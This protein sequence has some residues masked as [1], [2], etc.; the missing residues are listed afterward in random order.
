MQQS[1]RN[2]LVY[3]ILSGTIK[4][5]SFYY[6][7]PN[8]KILYDAQELYYET[9]EN[10]RFSGLIIKK[11][12]SNILVGKQ[13]LS[14]TIDSNIEEI[15]KSIENF[16]VELYQARLNQVKQSQTRKYLV[17]VKEKLE[18]SLSKK[19][20]LDLYTLEGY[21]E[22]VKNNFIYENCLVD[23]NYNKVILTDKLLTKLVSTLNQSY[24]S[25]TEYRE[26]ART[27]PWRSYWNAYKS[28]EV[29]DALG[30]NKEKNK[31]GSPLSLTMEQQ[32]LISYTKMYDNIYESPDCPEED[33]IEDD[34]VLDGWLILQRRKRESERKKENTDN[35]MSKHEHAQEIFIP[36]NTQT[37]IEKIND[38]NTIQGKIIKKQREGLIKHKGE[39]KD[40]EFIDKKIEIQQK[41][42]Q[43]YIDKIKGR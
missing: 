21:A 34:D 4:L 10:F 40:A 14:P 31:S 13:L 18:E 9:M 32:Y 17:L 39:V 8:I 43:N 29:F 16:K 7:Y 3:R 24:I 5:H 2:K 30:D 1:Q 33:I 6:V 22:S 37:D 35:F 38:L 12:T 19:H 20:A 41:Q 26:L 15:N 11:D 28:P 23:N 36:A 25:D 42:H 27:E